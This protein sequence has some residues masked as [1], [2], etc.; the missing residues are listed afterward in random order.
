MPK[1]ARY[2]LVWSPYHQTYEWRESSG[3]GVQDVAPESPTWLEWVGQLSSF[4]FHGRN[5]SY[6]MCKERKQR[7]EGYWYAYGVC[8]AMEQE[9]GLRESGK[10][11][12]SRRE[13]L[14]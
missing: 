8:G 12:N 3:S 9:S 10:R 11:R 7:G 6:T 5:G 1:T 14:S 13:A 4:A 2:G